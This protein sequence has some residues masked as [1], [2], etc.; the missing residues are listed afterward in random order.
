[1]VGAV[2]KDKVHVNAEHQTKVDTGNGIIVI[3]VLT[4]KS[5]AANDSIFNSVSSRSLSFVTEAIYVQKNRVNLAFTL[6]Y[7]P[8]VL[9]VMGD[10]PTRPQVSQ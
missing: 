1:M 9:E 8:P 2:T 4:I 10:L 6:H 7:D 5:P 3:F